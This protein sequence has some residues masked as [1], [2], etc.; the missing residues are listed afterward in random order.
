ME[1]FGIILVASEVVEF[2]LYNFIKFLHAL[3]FMNFMGKARKVN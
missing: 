2:E 1:F 3:N